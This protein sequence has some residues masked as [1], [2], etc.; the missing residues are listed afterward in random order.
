[1]KCNICDK[2]TTKKCGQCLVVRYCDR[3]CQRKDWPM[4]KAECTAWKTNV[5]DWINSAD[6]SHVLII[7]L[8]DKEQRKIIHQCIEETTKTYSRS[9]K[10]SCFPSEIRRRFYKRCYECNRK[11][12]PF[13]Y[14]DYRQGFM[15]NNQDESYRIACPKCGF[16]WYWECNYDGYDNIAYVYYNNCVVIGGEKMKHFRN[17]KCARNSKLEESSRPRLPFI[18][19]YA[20]IKHKHLPVGI[21]DMQ[22]LLACLNQPAVE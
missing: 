3:G 20:A 1:M 18:S 10:F 8:G 11:Y 14:E 17:M 22:H 13:G 4:H 19:S 2:Q 5:L 15:G 16:S 9:F 6:K 7:G 21:P 12:I